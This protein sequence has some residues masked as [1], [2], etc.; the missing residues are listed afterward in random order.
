MRSAARHLDAQCPRMWKID[1]FWSRYGE[2]A[3]SFYPMVI[4]ELLYRVI[5]RLDE[6]V[7]RA[8]LHGALISN[9]RRA[10]LSARLHHESSSARAIVPTMVAID[11]VHSLAPSHRGRHLKGDFCNYLRRTQTT[12]ADH[13]SFRRATRNIIR[14]ANAMQ[15][16]KRY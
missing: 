7:G 15:L 3:E 13:F 10:R 16:Q 5:N 4:S 8:F 2:M 6:E 1:R 14:I 9:R 12:V 11:I